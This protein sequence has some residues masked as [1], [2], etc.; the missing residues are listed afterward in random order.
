MDCQL[1][2]SEP[3]ISRRR[4]KKLSVSTSVVGSYRSTQRVSSKFGQHVVLYEVYDNKN[5]PLTFEIIPLLSFALPFPVCV[6]GTD[7]DLEDPL[8]EAGGVE[9]G[10]RCL[11]N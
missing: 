4:I 7:V 6:V 1:C 2:L 11:E 9:E 3:I 10:V 5:I 8:L